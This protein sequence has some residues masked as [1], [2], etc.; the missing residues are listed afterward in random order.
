MK[1]ILSYI[2]TFTMMLSVIGSVVMIDTEN[3]YARMN[4]DVNGNKLETLSELQ[5]IPHKKV[6]K[7]TLTPHQLR[8]SFATM[9]F[10]AELSPEDAQKFLGHSDIKTTVN[11]YTDIRAAKQKAAAN[12]LNAFVGRSEQ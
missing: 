8:H 2:L 6:R 5:R 11:I 7:T 10:E 3:A 12:K 1:R 4:V 9:C